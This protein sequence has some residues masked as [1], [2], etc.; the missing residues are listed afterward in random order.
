MYE[1]PDYSAK[2]KKQQVKRPSRIL[3]YSQKGYGFIQHDDGSIFFG[4]DNVVS[5]APSQGVQAYYEVG[6]DE[7]TRKVKA[8]EIYIR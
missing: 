5:G 7:C 2:S 6:V 4:C 8:R 3:F 1:K